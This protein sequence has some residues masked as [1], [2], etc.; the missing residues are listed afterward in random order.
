[1]TSMTAISLN[2]HQEQPL[3]GRDDVKLADRGFEL[4]VECVHEGVFFVK[5]MMRSMP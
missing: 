3:G 4:E 1:M 2:W 5:R